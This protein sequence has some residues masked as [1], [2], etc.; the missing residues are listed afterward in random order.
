MKYLVTHKS[1]NSLL[2][3]AFRQ[4]ADLIFKTFVESSVDCVTTDFLKFEVY[5]V[6]LLNL[7]ILSFQKNI[8]LFNLHNFDMFVT[9]K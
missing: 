5:F 4:E 9:I 1:K 6:E 3:E 2:I 8:I 7:Q